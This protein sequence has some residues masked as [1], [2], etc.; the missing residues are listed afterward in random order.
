M[1]TDTVHPKPTVLRVYPPPP[2]PRYWHRDGSTEVPT[3]EGWYWFNGKLDGRE[4]RGLVK[5]NR[6]D[7]SFPT[8]TVSPQWIDGWL[9]A[10]LLSGQW[11]G[12]L[13]A[14]WQD[15]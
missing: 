10:E 2:T 13:V 9:E 3:I 12:P 8:R 5:V 6:P 4:A 11:Y 14:P 7:A 1:T 15:E